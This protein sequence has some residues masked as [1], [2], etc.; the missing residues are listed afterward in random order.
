MNALGIRNG[1][2]PLVANRP[3][4]MASTMSPECRDS[5]CRNMY[6]H[7][8]GKLYVNEAAKQEDHGPP[9]TDCRMKAAN[10]LEGF[11]NRVQIL[12]TYI[13]FCDLFR[14]LRYNLRY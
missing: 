2:W 10:A 4:S 6:M 9:G 1:V 13:F 5:V 12:I 11:E 14:C 3:M 8:R 7:R